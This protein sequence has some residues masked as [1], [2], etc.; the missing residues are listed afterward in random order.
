MPPGAA[1]PVGQP[2]EQ[3]SQRLCRV[4]GQVDFGLVA[5]SEVAAVDIDL[6]GP[7]LAGRRQELGVG[8]VGADHQQ[9]VALLH[10]H[11]AGSGAQVADRAGDEGQV[12][13]QHGLAEEGLRYPGA[14]AVGDGEQLLGGPGRALAGEDGDALT[15]VEHPRRGVRAS[16]GGITCGCAHP[17]ELGTIPCS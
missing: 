3:R 7:G 16:S 2:G 8:L 4:P 15:C 13:G 14:E 6:D 11:L 5:R 17:G 10:E 1:I 12:V 9:G